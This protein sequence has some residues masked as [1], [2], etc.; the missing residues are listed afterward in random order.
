MQI[1][2]PAKVFNFIIEIN[3]VD[4]WAVQK[5]TVPELGIEVT[6]HGAANYDVKTAGRVTVGEASFDQLKPLPTITDEVWKWFKRA[7]DISRG[8]GKL[9]SAYKKVVVVK[10][11]YPDNVRTARRWILDGCFVSKISQSDL[12]R[13]SSDNILESVTLSVDAVDKR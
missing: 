1:A 2:D 13:N 6:S 12:D 5:F 7:Q 10:E 8:G 3:G 9:S 11:M 4:S